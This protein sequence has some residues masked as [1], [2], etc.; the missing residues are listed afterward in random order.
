MHVAAFEANRDQGDYDKEYQKLKERG[1]FSPAPP[2]RK[3]LTHLCLKSSLKNRTGNPHPESTHTQRSAGAGDFQGP[4]DIR[5]GHPKNSAHYSGFQL[6]LLGHSIL[7]CKFALS[8]LLSIAMSYDNVFRLAEET[9][10][11]LSSLRR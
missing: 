7:G 9:W 10:E 1:N 4:V 11:T 2:A 3:L 8:V 5:G 6:V